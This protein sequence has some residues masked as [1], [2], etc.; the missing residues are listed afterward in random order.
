MAEDFPEAVE[1]LGVA[2]AVVADNSIKRNLFYGLSIGAFN[3]QLIF[4]LLLTNPSIGPE[5]KPINFK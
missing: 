5:N 2:E 3:L 1:V 4:G